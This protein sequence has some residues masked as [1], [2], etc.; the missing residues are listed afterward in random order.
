M[1]E[2]L[3]SDSA[4]SQFQGDP[5]STGMWL[6]LKRALFYSDERKKNNKK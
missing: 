2:H 4:G 1:I 5:F 6:I 3:S